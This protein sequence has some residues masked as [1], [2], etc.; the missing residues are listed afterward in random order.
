MHEAAY[1]NPSALLK[2]VVIPPCIMDRAVL[3]IHRQSAIHVH[4]N[5]SKVN[6]F[7]YHLFLHEEQ[8]TG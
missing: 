3:L 4:L 7:S 5:L 8:Y 2:S 6:I 1:M